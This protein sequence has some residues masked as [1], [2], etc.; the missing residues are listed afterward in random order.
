LDT[1][2]LAHRLARVL[3]G[4]SIQPPRPSMGIAQAG[5]AFRL[6]ATTADIHAL[7]PRLFDVELMA[8][9]HPGRGQFDIRKPGDVMVQLFGDACFICSDDLAWKFLEKPD[10]DMGPIHRLLGSPEFLLAF[11]HYDSG[12]SHGYAIAEHGRRTRTRL[13]T[14]GL[15]HL[16]PLQERGAPMAFELPWLAAP[17]YLEADDDCPPEERIKVY[18]QGDREVEV[19]EH[20]LTA[21]MLQDGL[22][23]VFGVC[24][25]ATDIEPAY[26]F[27]TPRPK[28]RPWWKLRRS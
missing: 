22:Q 16:P 13:Q 5:L 24:P 6:T 27:F 4:R 9:P 17:F 11:C 1:D 10:E 20:G 18:Y 8:I 23:S 3:G 14:I 21:R 25:W 19:P 12:G 15:P 7:V 2:N 26:H 28:K